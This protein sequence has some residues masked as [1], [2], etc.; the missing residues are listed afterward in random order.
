MH[1]YDRQKPIA[2]KNIKIANFH[3]NHLLLNGSIYTLLYDTG[4]S[5]TIIMLQLPVQELFMSQS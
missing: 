3:F 2:D 1:A 4:D 5:K